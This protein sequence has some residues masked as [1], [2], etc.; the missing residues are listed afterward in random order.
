VRVRRMVEE[1]RVCCP[2]LVIELE[3]T[4]EAVSVKIT[5]PGQDPAMRDVLFEHFTAGIPARLP[6]RCLEQGQTDH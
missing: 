1:E 3:E 2:F 4:A 5:P 6:P